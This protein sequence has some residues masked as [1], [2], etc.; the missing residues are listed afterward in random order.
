MP[1]V[2]ITGSCGFVGRLLA[3]RMI[4]EGWEVWGADVVEKNP[5][6]ERYHSGDLTDADTVARII[7]AANPKCI[8]HLAGQSSV[9][10]SFGDPAGTILAN[11]SPAL[12]I[13]EHIRQSGA[14]TR[15]LVV[16]SAEEYG[17]VTPE[18]LPVAE[19]APLAPASPYALSKAIQGKCA[20]SYTSMYDVDTVVTRSFNHTGPGQSDTFALSSFARQIAEIRLGKREPLLEVGN[21]DVKRDFLDV[22]DVCG[23]YIALLADGQAGEVYNVCSGTSYPLQDMVDELC[24]HAGTEVEVRVD[25]ARL[26]PVDV[27][28]LRGDGTKLARATGWKPTITIEETLEA[29]VAHWESSIS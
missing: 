7:E 13:L 5:A 10:K 25:P 24:R 2:L 16:G 4:D 14:K 26:R 12:H 6:E 21:L 20:T 9:G 8:V 3:A 22:R 18:D 27:P 29:L 15:V 23:A 1:T 11:T 19:D 17:V 28:E